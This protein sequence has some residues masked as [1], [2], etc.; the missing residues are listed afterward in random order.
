[1]D[2]HPV[3]ILLAA[4]AFPFFELFM[5]LLDHHYGRVHHGPN[6]DRDPSQ[7]HDVR[8]QAHHLHRN[9]CNDHCH[10]NGDDRN[11]GAGDVPE[12]DHDD[13]GHD[14]QLFGESALQV[15][16][17]P[18]DQ[19]GPVVCGNYLHPRRK[20][21]LR[22]F[23]FLLDTLD[24]LQGVLSLAHDD[25]AGDRLT[26]PV[27]VRNPTADVGS[28]SHFSHVGYAD[29]NTARSLRQ[30]DLADVGGGL[31][32]AAAAHHVLGAAEFHQTA[33]DVV[34]AAAHR[35]HYLANRNVER[36]QLVWIDVDLVLPHESAQWRDLGDAG[37]R[38]QIV[39]KVPVLI[40]PQ[41]S[42]AL[43]ARRVDQGILKHPSNAGSVRSEFGFDALGQSRQDVREVFQGAGARPIDV[44]SFFEDDVDI[45]VPEVGKPAHVLDFRRPQ[46]GGDQRVRDLVFHDV[47]TAIPPRIDDHLGVA[48]V[49]ERVERYR[50]HRP[51][52]GHH[53][54]TEQDEDDDLVLSRELYDGVYH[55]FSAPMPGM[56]PISF[57]PGFPGAF[58]WF[59][60]VS[61]FAG[62]FVIPGI[63]AIPPI[64]D[65]AAF[66]WL[67]ESIRKLPDVTIRS[68]W[69]RPDKIWM[70]SPSRSPVFTCLGSK[71][72]V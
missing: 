27:P 47:R 37:N 21:A 44:R 54:R 70:R 71:S 10:G 61:G 34:V 8:C 52:P 35:R 36:L 19:F 59:A 38:F 13:D 67:S 60:G 16:D 1:I 9:E 2:H 12:E 39:T 30:H 40:T 3:I 58:G 69:L 15:L 29:G 50:P 5:G 18:Q 32:V 45:R 66:I 25:N 14:D 6:R 22:V 24:H 72:V 51:Q 33:A 49:R 4:R 42:Q 7:G 48:H 53:R 31:R 28:Q 63:P 57:A 64:P 20:S 46:H 68:P 26:C 65:A 17:G 62:L 55:F 11:G 23:E 43:L 41:V 56:S